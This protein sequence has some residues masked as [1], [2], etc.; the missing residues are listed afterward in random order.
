[1]ETELDL[2][3]RSERIRVERD[4][5]LCGLLNGDIGNLCGWPNFGSKSC[6]IVL[7]HFDLLVVL[8]QVCSYLEFDLTLCVVPSV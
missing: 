7:I 3:Y 4:L 2:D 1:V 8:A 6:V 5:A